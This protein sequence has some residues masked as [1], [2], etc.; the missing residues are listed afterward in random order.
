MTLAEQW[1][2]ARPP[3]AGVHTD[4]AAC[5][6]Q[7]LAVIDAAARHARHEAEVGGYVA[8]EAAA[9]ALDAGRA[10][11]R[12]L[13]T[14]T[15]AEVFFTTGSS[16]ALDVLLSSWRGERRL[17]CLPGEFG[18]NLAIMAR[19]GF[20]IDPLP[21]DDD[22]R[23]DPDGAARAL[24]VNPPALVHFTMLGSHRGTVQPVRAIAVTCRDLGIPLV[25]DAAQ[26][27]GHLD[28]TGIGADAIYTS[29][30]KWTAG[31]R[32]VGL[33][34]TRPGLLPE[35]D[36]LRLRH[37]EANVG[38]HVGLCVA[39]GELMACGPETVQARLRE[40]GTMTR[41]TLAAAPGWQVIEDVDEPSAITTLYPCDGVDPMTVRARLIA[42]HSIVTTYLGVERAP[43]EMTRPALRIS[44]HVDITDS[45]LE[46]VAAA[47]GSLTH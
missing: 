42:E 6:R 45:D 23:L 38:L 37:A 25:V 16:H 35:A 12:A 46:A 21:V 8:A 13:T 29:S 18:P 32:G 27:F 10:A 31:P 20:E 28:C 24:A 5:S 17:A 43:R 39:L 7:S 40:V 1:R 36:R 4:S 14:M 15:D 33:L 2:A 41:A 3:V 19:H 47:L 34:I 22:G 30:R 26:G 44:P 9:P 11:V